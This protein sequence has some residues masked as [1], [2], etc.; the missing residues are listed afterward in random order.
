M[1]QIRSAEQDLSSQRTDIIQ[2]GSSRVQGP[3]NGENRFFGF[4][5]NK[6]V[7]FNWRPITLQYCIGFAILQHESTMDVHVFLI[8]N[9]TPTFPHTIPLGHPSAPAPSTL[10]HASNE[11]RF[12]SSNR[13]S[14]IVPVVCPWHVLP[15][16]RLSRLFPET[17]SLALRLIL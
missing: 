3:L 1:T 10:Y 9:P 16:A 5:L 17:D 2:Y 12:C 14:Q 4:F 11:N 13:V 15:A 6:F 8:L 7:Y